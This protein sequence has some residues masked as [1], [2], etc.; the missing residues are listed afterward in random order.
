ME[1]HPP[2]LYVLSTLEMWERFSFYGMEA[3]LFLFALNV[4]N[5]SME[6]ASIIFGVYT[7]LTFLTPVFGGY[8]S[9]KYLGNRKSIYIGGILMALGQFALTF[10]ASLYNP[11]VKIPIHS[12][13]IFST[14][15]IFL[16]LGLLILVIGNGFFKAN[17]SSLVRFLYVEDDERLDSAFTLFYMGINIGSFLSPI[18]IG[19]LIG[20]THPELYQYGFLLSGLGLIAGLL[21]FT[22]FK[23]K[24]VI[25]PEGDLVGIEPSSKSKREKLIEKEKELG[26]ESKT[27]LTKIE[28]DRIKAIFLLALFTVLYWSASEQSATSLMYFAQSFMAKTIAGITFPLEWYQSINPLGVVLF[29][30]ILAGLWMKL[31]DMGKEPSIPIKMGIGMLLLAVSFVIILPAGIQ[32]D[33]GIFNIPVFYLIL[34]NTVQAVAELCISPTGQSLVAK[35]SPVR[36]SSLMM[37]IWYMA[38]AVAEIIGALTA[39]LYPV[40]GNPTPYF[41][42]LI[43]IPNLEAFFLIF[44]IV[45]AFIGMLAFIFKGRIIHLMHGIE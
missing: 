23:N 4:L 42:G 27:K 19:L 28:K 12:S 16:I 14:Q 7:G 22:V 15:E 38:T 5:C 10:S 30:P 3:L 41:L 44:I 8:L 1:S 35:L 18:I 39:G 26:H 45:S 33:N 17:I 29:A 40:A 24:Y 36:Y 21:I 11:A 34:V 43:P 2:G 37:G 9:D 6:F 31:S 32:A 20:T 25:S 13:F